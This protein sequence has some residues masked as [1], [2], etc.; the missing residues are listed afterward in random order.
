MGFKPDFH[1][2]I[3]FLQTCFNFENLRFSPFSMPVRNN[4]D[5]E[6]KLDLSNLVKIELEILA[7]SRL[8]ENFPELDFAC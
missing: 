3:I 4:L 8:I 6:S 7:A 5:A 1:Q 2:Y